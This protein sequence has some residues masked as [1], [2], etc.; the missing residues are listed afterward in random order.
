MD[1]TLY[2]GN[3][4]SFCVQ[5]ILEGKMDPDQVVCIITAVKGNSPEAVFDANYG[6]YWHKHDQSIAYALFFEL[7]PRLCMPRKWDVNTNIA[8][9]DRWIKA[10]VVRM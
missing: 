8:G 9:Q 2:I 10:N 6:L 1:S 5:D 3:S 4:L 7:W